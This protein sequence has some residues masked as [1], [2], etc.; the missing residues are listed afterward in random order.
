MTQNQLFLPVLFKMWHKSGK[1]NSDQKSIVITILTVDAAQS[2]TASSCSSEE[3]SPSWSF[4]KT[5]SLGSF[6][7]SV[8]LYKNCI[9][10]TVVALIWGQFVYGAFSNQALA[11]SSLQDYKQ[12]VQVTHQTLLEV[13]QSALAWGCEDLSVKDYP[14]LLT[15]SQC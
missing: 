15:R 12:D 7:L 10:I 14:H 8:T 6:Y 11:H 1:T 13:L 4:F 2:L 3:N 5:A 9:S